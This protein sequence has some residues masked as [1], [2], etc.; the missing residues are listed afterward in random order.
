[1]KRD[2]IAELNQLAEL[3]SRWLEYSKRT[4]GTEDHAYGEDEGK[5]VRCYFSATSS[6]RT[7]RFE[8]SACGIHCAFNP[9]GLPGNEAGILYSDV[10]IDN[11]TRLPEIIKTYSDYLDT[12]EAAQ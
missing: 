12:L 2:I 9:L 4:N 1:M 7:A 5:F 10:T 8:G 6:Y 3:S 11:L